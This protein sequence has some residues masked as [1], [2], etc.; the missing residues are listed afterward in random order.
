MHRTFFKQ[1]CFMGKRSTNTGPTIRARHARYSENIPSIRV[2]TPKNH[3]TMQI[4]SR[5]HLQILLHISRRQKTN[6]QKTQTQANN[7]KKTNH[8]ND[9]IDWYREL[10]GYVLYGGICIQTFAHGIFRSI[11]V[12]SYSIHSYMRVEQVRG[13]RAAFRCDS[14]Q[15]MLHAIE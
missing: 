4:R 8:R 1:L 6:K 13:R 5:S 3:F 11:Y 15:N 10:G 2:R 12:S 9:H 7:T 14:I